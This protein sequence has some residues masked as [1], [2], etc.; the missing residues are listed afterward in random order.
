MRTDPPTPFADASI[1]ETPRPVGDARSAVD[2]IE[3]ARVGLSGLNTWLV[4]VLIPQLHSGLGSLGQLALST[5]ALFAVGIGVASLRVRIDLARWILLA[6]APGVLAA[7]IAARPELAERDA[8]GPIGLAL[9]V[10]SLLAYL[11]SAAHAVSRDRSLKGAQAHPLV[12]KEP[13]REPASRGWLRRALLVIAGLGAFAVAV[14]APALPDRRARSE[15]WGESADDAAVLAAIVAALAAAVALGTIIGPGLRAARASSSEEKR[16]WRRLGV[17][18]A[19][20]AAAGV[21][22]LVLHYFDLAR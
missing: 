9:S 14:V 22:W 21:G 18:I 13:V 20:A 7:V 17:A 19:M 15:A 10:A 16:R 6:I 5:L 12:G 1:A 4:A 3:L 2:R 8:Y 11:A